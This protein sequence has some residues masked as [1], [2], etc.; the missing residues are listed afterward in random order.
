M[1]HLSEIYN[2]LIETSTF[3][4]KLKYADVKAAVKEDSRTCKKKYR[5]TS[6]LP[7]VSKI[8]EWC[9]NKQLEVYFQALLSRYQCGFCKGYSIINVL[10]RMTK[11]WRKSFDEGGPFGALLTDF[12]KAFDCLPHELLIAKLHAYGVDI[13]SLKL[14]LSYLTKQKRRMKLNGTYSS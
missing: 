14:L 12:S 1:Q 11:K 3:S 7:H 6:I 13:S 9:L 8:Y 5:P 2:I 4:E 10:V